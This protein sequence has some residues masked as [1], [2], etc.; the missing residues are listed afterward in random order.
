[1]EN[2]L[3]SY[4]KR[5]LISILEKEGV[6]QD[7]NEVVNDLLM[8]IDEYAWRNSHHRH[9]YFK[10]RKRLDRIEEKLDEVLGSSQR[11]RC[12]FSEESD[13][14][15]V[16]QLITGVGLNERNKAI[17][18]LSEKLKGT[19]SLIICDPYF[20]KK[21]KESSPKQ[22]AI[23]FLGTLPKSLK[24]L[25]V[26]VKPRIRDK[27]FAECLNFELKKRNIKLI[28]RRTEDIHDR[29]WIK[30]YDEAFVVGTSFNGLGNK[31]AFILD[32]PIED[33]KQFIY[34]L[35]EISQKLPKSK[36]A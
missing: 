1:M 35:N 6:E 16:L 5:K 22:T 14:E 23:E 33:R 3:K 27:E 20:L 11:G 34:S 29:V 2:E 26:Y 13:G 30:D 15:S 25:D 31:C 17:K 19:R 32:L 4:L 9:Y 18:H 7:L 8:D 10:E 36:S 24:S 12:R 28:L 21:S